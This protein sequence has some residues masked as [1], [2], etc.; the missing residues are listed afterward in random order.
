MQNERVIN[1]LKEKVLIDTYRCL[2]QNE[3]AKAGL[4]Q[5]KVLIDTYRCLMQNGEVWLNL[6]PPRS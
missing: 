2:M 5:A 6:E 3:L 1:M 4:D